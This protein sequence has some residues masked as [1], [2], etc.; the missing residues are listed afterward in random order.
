MLNSGIQ[1]PIQNGRH[2]GFNA[3]K[4]L[5]QPNHGRSNAGLVLAAVARSVKG[6]ETG[7]ESVGSCNIGANTG[8]AKLAKK[9][10]WTTLTVGHLLSRWA[11]QYESHRSFQFI[12]G[13]FR[14]LCN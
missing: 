6:H 11:Q 8:A 13:S 4:I 2:A 9:C 5:V 3:R 1:G 14:S 12:C 10:A 7:G